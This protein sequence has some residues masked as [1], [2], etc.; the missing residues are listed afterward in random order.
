M[1]SID[2]LNGK[3]K[4]TIYSTHMSESDV[5]FGKY[6]R[7]EKSILEVDA[8]KK[9]KYIFIMASSV[10]SII[11]TDIKSICNDIQS[12]VQANL[13]PITTGGLKEDYNEGVKEALNLL[14][15]NVVKPLEDFKELVFLEGNSK[16]LDG[17]NSLANL[18]EKR[19]CRYNI[20]GANIDSYNYLSDVE[21]V[22]RIMKDIFNK[23][24]N[25]VFTAYTSIDEIERATLA[26]LNIVL[27]EEALEA[28]K[29]MEETF[30]IPYVYGK[31]IGLKATLKWIND[32]KELMC[33]RELGG[34]N[35]VIDYTVNEEILDKEVKYIK[36]ALFRFK[37]KLRA[38]HN[39]KVA[40]FGDY[41]TV[42]SMKEFLEDIG[43]VTSRAE[44][45]H[46]VRSNNF[47]EI[48]SKGIIVNSGDIERIKYLR[49]EEL[50]LLMGDGPSLDMEH[51]S[52]LDIQ[53]SNP[54]LNRVN[55][56]PYTPFVGLRGV[57]YLV[58]RLCNIH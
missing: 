34:C 55:M 16:N 46:N 4:A 1:E 52:V 51:S 26:S 13:I 7:L 45:L 37:F 43:L 19:K 29:Y 54:N 5:T 3:D 11:G 44:I 56:Y 58:E 31:P 36:D 57:L 17:F 9:P 12:R 49:D 8:N 21:E 39:K 32:I 28:A 47:E 20:L 2:Q 41:N 22:K 30:N 33:H 48:K 6:D 15:K 24:V 27:R 42:L 38:L 25:T 18:E 40:I 23:E 10:S 35:E 50:L 14:V 53:I